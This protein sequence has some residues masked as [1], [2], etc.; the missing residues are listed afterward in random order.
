MC[1]EPGCPVSK[2]LF[3]LELEARVVTRSVAKFAVIFEKYWGTV[4]QLKPGI[5]RWVDDS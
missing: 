4:L 5:C 2:S 1:D 3:K